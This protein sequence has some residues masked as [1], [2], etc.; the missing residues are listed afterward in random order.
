MPK[1]KSVFL[2]LH[3]LPHDEA[4]FVIEKFIT[5][6]FQKMPIKIITGY[7]D[8]FIGRIKFYATKYELGCYRVS[9]SNDGC[10]IFFL[11]DWKK[12][13]DSNDK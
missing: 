11:D 9:P 10:W 13:L 3:G 5:D 4:D 7:S 1:K 8:F 12:V 2:D 6:N